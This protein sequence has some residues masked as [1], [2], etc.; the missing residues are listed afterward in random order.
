M[1]PAIGII[2]VFIYSGIYVLVIS[3][4]WNL[5]KVIVSRGLYLQLLVGV[6]FFTLSDTILGFVIFGQV[7]GQTFQ[8][9]NLQLALSTWTIG[10]FLV[11][12]SLIF[13]QKE[14]PQPV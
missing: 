4:A 14:L 3:F 2:P 6:I 12:Y 11:F 1:I 10:V 7:A 9:L 13:I 8:Y 5:G